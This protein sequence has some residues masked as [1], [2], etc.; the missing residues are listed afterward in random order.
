MHGVGAV[1]RLFST[2]ELQDD[3]EVALVHTG[4]DDGFRALSEPMVNVRAT[5]Q[6]AR[7][8][9]ILNPPI[10]QRLIDAAKRLHFSCRTLSNILTEADLPSADAGVAREVFRI[11]YV[12]LKAA[13]A[14]LLLE[15]V[16]DLVTE[17]S[18]KPRQM[19]RSRGFERLYNNERTVRH[20]GT[21][22]SLRSIAAHAALSAPDFDELNFSAL[23]RALLLVLAEMLQ[24][25]PTEPE[26]EAET[27]RF[28]RTLGLTDQ[29][30]LHDWLQGNDL[31]ATAFG[32]LIREVATTRR[33][34][35][36]ILGSARAQP[37]RW[38]LDELRLRGRY[39]ETVADVAQDWSG[40][41]EV[42]SVAELDEVV[43]MDLVP[44]HLDATGWRL[45]API[46]EWA[47]EAGFADLKDLAYELLQARR[48]RERRRVQVHATTSAESSNGRTGH[49]RLYI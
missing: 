37:T 19:V 46:A 26:I 25:E 23:N 33:L 16:R 11:Q 24:L 38:L 15:T 12:D 6:H 22:I 13:D 48:I 4:A 27:L 30:V 35:R 17:D 45:N 40:R 20:S 9:G 34:H 49:G 43:L 36:W 1:F 3:D 8:A 21:D 10:A 7:D 47:L 31:N 28:R 5:V 14:R 41:S 18:P 32:A 39:A 42:E 29:N 44:A 2:G